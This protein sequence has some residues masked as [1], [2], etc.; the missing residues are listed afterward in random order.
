MKINL[1]PFCSIPGMEQ[2]PYV[3][4]LG[5]VITIDGDVFDFS[6]LPEGATLPA[7]LVPSD[8]IVGNVD[9]TDGEISLTLRFPCGPNPPFHVAFPSPIV[10]HE[11]PVNL[12]K[13]ISDVDA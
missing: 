3:S 8:W 5:D 4:V 12:P 2:P 13:E 6:T 11:G 9:K 1:S 10:I 7:G